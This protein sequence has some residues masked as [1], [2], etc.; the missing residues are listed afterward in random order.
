[1][2][3]ADVKSLLWRHEIR[4]WH[5]HISSACYSSA[6]DVSTPFVLVVDERQETAAVIGWHPASQVA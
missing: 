3:Y 5:G 1:M 2:C 4:N 6:T